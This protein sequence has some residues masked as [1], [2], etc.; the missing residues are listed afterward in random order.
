MTKPSI[1][2]P[3]AL[4]CALQAAFVAPLVMVSAQALAITKVVESNQTFTATSGTPS[5]NYRVMENATLNVQGSRT[6][7]I[8]VRKGQ[9]NIDGG[10]VTAGGSNNAVA[11]VSGTARIANA[12]IDS[13]QGSGLTIGR[14]LDGSAT[15]SEVQVQ[16]SEITGGRF[17]A[18]LS[19]YSSLSLKDSSL[20]GAT[21]DGLLMIGGQAQAYNS[22]IEGAESGVRLSHEYYGSEAN[23]QAPTLLL[24]NSKV[25]GGTGAALVVDSATTARI[26]VLNGSSLEGAN[27]NLLELK[28]AGSADMQVSRS[29]LAGNILVG[30]GSTANL[31]LSNASLEGDVIVAAGGAAQLSLNDQSLFK[32]RLENVDA[33][34]LNGDSTWALIGDSQVEQLSLQGGHV[35]FGE[36]GQFY[37]LDLGELSGNG[38]FHMSADFATGEADLLNVSGQADGQHT[39]AIS[40]S[41]HDPAA[42]ERITVVTTGG[43]DA[44]FSLLNGPVDLGAFSYGLTKEGNDWHLDTEKKVIS[45]GTRSVLAL[46]NTA[47]T[48]WYGELSSLRTRMGELRYNEGKSGAWGRA[49]GSKYNVA[50]SSGTAYKQTQQ[51]FTLGADAQLGDS[52]WLVGVLAGHS[53][54]DLDLS[55]GTSGTVDSYYAGAYTTW[56]DQDSGYYFDAVAK[57]NRFD[58]KSKVAM[59]DGSQAK[60]NYKTNGVGASAEFGRH[61]KLDDGYFVEP[62]AQVS[63][64]SIQ[65][66]SYD[67]DS[68]LK[69]EGDRTTSVLGKAG[70]TVGRN[71]DL[72][73]G[74][75]AQPYLRAAAVHEFAKNNQVKVNDNVFNNDLSGSRAEVG[76]GIAVSL[77]ERLQLHADIDY[78]NGDK[79]EKPFGANVGVRFTW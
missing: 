71:F 14:L 60:G 73:E 42:V 20:S 12:R 34:A 5:Y 39:L 67:L 19:A 37:R 64:V 49:Y 6:E 35:Q 17:G 68:G 38:T 74:R 22:V 29:T 48:I 63:A 45:P 69:A 27:G 1:F 23:D 8:Q 43:G 78:S 36:P 53:K 66:A 7:H 59:S 11:L 4:S 77:S 52:Q 15:G 62:F 13:A 46:F 24:D 44:E 56:L 51:G 18:T 3:S 10:T 72:G 61:I 2:K 75:F 21:A 25:I 16:S 47:P 41:G 33:L 32:G 31:D 40:A 50:E 55:R 9:L 65:G 28:N 26:D 54:S 30:E 57:V 70:A 79:I 58:N 76:A